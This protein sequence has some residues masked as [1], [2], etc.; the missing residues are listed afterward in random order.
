MKGF[1]IGIGAFAIVGALFLGLTVLDFGCGAV[2]NAS[3]VAKKEF[4]PDA[5]LRKYEWFKDAA[6]GLDKK[7]ADIGVY[8]SRVTDLKSQYVGVSRTKWARDDREQ[9]SIWQSEEA[10]IKASYNQLAAEYNAEMAKFNWAFTNV[11]QVPQ[12]GKPLPR[13]YKPYIE[14]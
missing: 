8:D 9:L 2:Q 3:D 5:M 12:G 13:E 4:Y 14:Q 10:G 6:A 1:V 7:A 11:G